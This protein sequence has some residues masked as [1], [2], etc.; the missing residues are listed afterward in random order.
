MKLPRDL[1][2]EALVHALCTR[3]GYIRVHQSGSHVILETA[4]PAH[5]R[6]AVPAHATLRIGTLSAI[7]R[8]VSE[9]KGVTRD[10][11]LA[12]L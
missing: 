7:L 12:I 6:L 10:Q 8:A 2:G 4:E 1:S 9:R 3:W 11:V 5:Q